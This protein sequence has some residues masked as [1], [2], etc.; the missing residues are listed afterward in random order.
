M[1]ER[2]ILE[3]RPTGIVLVPHVIAICVIIGLVTIWKAIV[4]VLTTRLTITNKRV[5]GKKGLL[6][7]V[8]MDSRIG[9]IT[10]VKVTQGI[11][12]KIFNYGTIN[13]NTA[14]GEY[15]FNYIKNPENVKQTINNAMDNLE[16]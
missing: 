7:T 15:E 10:S 3:A 13:I 9:Q 6:K 16:K 14:G 4:A 1:V 11:A 12:G 2:V 5:E 8:K